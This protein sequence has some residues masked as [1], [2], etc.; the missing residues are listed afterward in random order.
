MTTNYSRSQSYNF[1]ELTENQQLEILNNY[2]FEI[3]D[4][5]NTSFVKLIK[6]N[7]TNPINNVSEFIP[8]SMFMRVD[9]NNFTHGIYS[10]SAFD[11]YF[12]TFSRD[13]EY[14][15]IAHKYF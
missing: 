8:L 4:C 10:T 7:C 14:C 5:H 6:T 1:D 12:V 2:S 11:G 9:N 15:T 3:S 13:N